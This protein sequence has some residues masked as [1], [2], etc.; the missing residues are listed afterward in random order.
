MTSSLLGY[1]PCCFSRSLVRLTWVSLEGDES[2]ALGINDRFHYSD[3]CLVPVSV[4]SL[5]FAV[6]CEC[7]VVYDVTKSVPIL[8][9]TFGFNSDSAVQIDS[10]NC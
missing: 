5:F 8:F 2:R 6:C 9:R 10:M 1:V 4:F 3:V 7:C